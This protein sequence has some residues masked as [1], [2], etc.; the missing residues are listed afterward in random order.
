[1]KKLILFS[2]AMACMIVSV[3]AQ[4][5]QEIKPLHIGDTVPDLTFTNMLNYNAP[6]AKLSDFK[7]KLV[8]LDFWNTWCG[9]CIDAMPKMDSVQ[10][11]FGNK[12][13]ILLVN[14]RGPKYDSKKRVE[15]VLT[16]LKKRTGFYPDLPISILDTNMNRY[17]PHQ[18]VPHEVWIN[19]HNRVIA[20]TTVQNVTD[21]N[22]QMVLSGHDPDMEVKNDLAFKKMKPVWEQGSGINDNEFIYRSVFTP[23]IQNLG[24]HGGLRYNKKHQVIGVYNTNESLISYVRSAYYKLLD[25]SDHRMDLEVKDPKR[26]NTMDKAYYYCYDLWVPPVSSD[27]F[28]F[29]YYIQEDLKRAFHIRARLEK[30][31]MPCWILVGV[32]KKIALAFTRYNKSDGDLGKTTI[33]KYLHHYSVSEIATAFGGHLK[34]PLIDETGLTQSIDIDFPAHFTWPKDPQKV[35]KIL[36]DIGFRIKQENRKLNVLV[37]TDQ[38]HD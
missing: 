31:T 11:R 33:R 37:V 34:H 28:D 16:G 4:P 32:D 20:V 3:H 25:S 18:S 30:R 13:Q 7:G 12:I 35:L 23:Y 9:S 17:F 2:M 22:I 6:A 14:S 15:K 19:A 21:H 29:S 5:P 1:M 36:T 8:I 10:A 24:S 26:F 38:W 27:S